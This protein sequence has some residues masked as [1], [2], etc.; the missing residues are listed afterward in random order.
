[1]L[2][3]TSIF[4]IFF[5]L[6]YAL[7]VNMRHRQQNMLLPHAAAP[8]GRSQAVPATDGREPKSPCSRAI[9]I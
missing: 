1:M 2:F 5:A 8:S 3:H 7:Y 9:Q 6:T 4:A